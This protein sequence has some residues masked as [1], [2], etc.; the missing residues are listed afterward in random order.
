MTNTITPTTN[1]FEFSTLV[2]QELKDASSLTADE[3]NA[4]RAHPNGWRDALIEV[5][6]RTERQFTA[7]NAKV[8][9]AGTKYVMERTGDPVIDRAK[10]KAVQQAIY[11]ASEWRRKNTYFLSVIERRIVYVNGL[12]D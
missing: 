11:E 2:E 5:K 9:T 10:Y 12:L 1:T 3:R 8:T 7:S 6:K 4:L